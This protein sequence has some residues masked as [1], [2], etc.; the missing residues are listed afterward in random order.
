MAHLCHCVEEAGATN[1]TLSLE[2][3]PASRRTSRGVFLSRSADRRSVRFAV[4]PR[5]AKNGRT[6]FR[7]RQT[8]FYFGG[9]ELLVGAAE[10]CTGAVCAAGLDSALC[11]VACPVG[12]GVGVGVPV[13]FFSV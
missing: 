5:R 3:S 8:P 4:G 6:L 9:A 11:P 12:A 10:G 7:H 13:A 2:P 1:G